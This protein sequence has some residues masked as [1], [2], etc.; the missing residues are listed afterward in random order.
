MLESEEVV[1]FCLLTR[2]LRD[3]WHFDGPQNG[4]AAGIPPPALSSIVPGKIRHGGRR[5]AEA[6][7]VYSSENKNYQFHITVKNFFH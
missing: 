2:R 7:P 4:D 1:S 5:L 6:V 3:N